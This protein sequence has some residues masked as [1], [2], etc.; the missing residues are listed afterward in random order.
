[1][2]GAVRLRV[3]VLDQWEDIVM[4][5]PS[6]TSISAVKE[7]ALAAVHITEDAANFVIKFRGAAIGD[8]ARSLGDEQVPSDA[9]LIVMRRRRVPVR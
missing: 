6:T 2:S 5:L 4:D 9:G 1:M 8:E 3:R 7:S